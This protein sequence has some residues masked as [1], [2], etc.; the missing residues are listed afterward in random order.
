MFEE[1]LPTDNE[2]TV[3]HQVLQ[4][5][6]LTGC[7]RHGDTRSRA[8]NLVRQAVTGSQHEDRK[9]AASLSNS[10]TDLHA[11]TIRKTKV[12]DRNVTI[13]R[14][15]FVQRVEHRAGH[16]NRVAVLT[17]PTFDDGGKGHVVFN[18]Q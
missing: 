8:V 10:P 9:I 7:E 13:I 2:V 5:R 15:E 17:K 11:I 16:I 4:K 14:V 18:Q 6:K 3:A 12:K 1:C